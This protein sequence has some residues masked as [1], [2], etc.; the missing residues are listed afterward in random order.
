MKYF[1][2]FDDDGQYLAVCSYVTDVPFGVDPKRTYLGKPD[3]KTQYHDL[4]IG[5]PV[6]MPPRPSLAHRFNFKSKAWEIN[7]AVITIHVLGQRAAL[8]DGSDW[9]VTRATEAGQ[10]VPEAWRIYRQA[11]RDITAQPGYPTDIAWP[12]APSN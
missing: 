5:Q 9:I 1:A 2:K 8:L 3:P 6:N 11:L 7:P 12:V 4:R 10:P